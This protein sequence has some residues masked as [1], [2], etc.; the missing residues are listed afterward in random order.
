MLS[1]SYK[2]HFGKNP[3]PCTKVICSIS[4]VISCCVGVSVNII[5]DKVFIGGISKNCDVSDFSITV[6][7][8]S[9][10]IKVIYCSPEFFVGTWPRCLNRGK[11]IGHKI[12]DSITDIFTTPPS[13]S[14][15]IFRFGKDDFVLLVACRGA[16]VDCPAFHVVQ[17]FHDNFEIWFWFDNRIDASLMNLSFYFNFA[18]YYTEST[19]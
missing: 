10:V 5:Y 11:C 4:P 6:N 15:P 18:E 16:I 17:P 8:S 3:G 13:V 9:F 12:T 1:R 7:E 2:T 14:D 19:L